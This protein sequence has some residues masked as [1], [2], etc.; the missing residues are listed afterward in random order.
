MGKKISSE[1]LIKNIVEKG[2]ITE[3][4]ILLLKHRLNKGEDIDLSP[5]D[6]KEIYVTDEQA[7]KGL[8]YLREHLLTKSNR[9]RKN[10]GWDYWEL[11]AIGLIEEG[12]P[13]KEM[14]THKLFRFYGFA[15]IG[16]I[17]PYYSPIYEINGVL[18]YMKC[19]EPIVY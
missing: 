8:T 6:E 19:G 13:L 7:Q 11:E 12:C 5:L 16:R 4:E 17:I 14:S 18:Y 3:R 2:V 15:N 9:R 10:C 1:E